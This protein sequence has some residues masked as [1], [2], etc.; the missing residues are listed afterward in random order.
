MSD[1]NGLYYMR[2]RYYNIDIK[3]FINQDVIT[4]SIDSSPSLNRYAYVEGNPV[5][6]LDPFG[7]E[8]SIWNE[9][10]NKI[11][12]IAKVITVLD[13]LL[14]AATIVL[15]SVNPVFAAVTGDLAWALGKTLNDLLIMDAFIVAAD[16]T[17]LEA[18]SNEW[19]QNL[20]DIG[21][22]ILG[23]V[24]PDKLATSLMQGAE[25]T[26]TT[27][28]SWMLDQMLGVINEFVNQF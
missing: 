26:V 28:I 14:I 6:Y 9:I 27:G 8:R 16:M 7:L 1:D 13:G 20:A 2:A 12:T 17:T 21:A 22:N 4:G 24:V 23:I 18:F 11:Q 3:R 15:T 19:F 5:S 25:G 10:H